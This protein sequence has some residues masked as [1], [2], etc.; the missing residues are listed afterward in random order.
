MVTRN[1][2]C[3][4]W[5]GISRD[6]STFEIY[7][8]MEDAPAEYEI[9]RTRLVAGIRKLDELD[10]GDAEY[11]FVTGRGQGPVLNS[12]RRLEDG[13]LPILHTTLIDEDIS[14]KSVFFVSLEQSPLCL[15]YNCQAGT[16]LVVGIPVE[17]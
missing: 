6:I 1:Q 8:A 14:Y 15:V 11:A 9:I 10:N 16:G 3:P 4:T 17:L 2:A 13:I 5:L 12:V 7:Y